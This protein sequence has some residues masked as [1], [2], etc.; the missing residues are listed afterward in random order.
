MPKSL[1]TEKLCNLEAARS[2]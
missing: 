1:N 2:L